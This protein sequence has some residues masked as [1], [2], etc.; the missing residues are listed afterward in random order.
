MAQVIH[1]S[2]ASFL[3][4][5]LFDQ[6]AMESLA[7]VIEEQRIQLEANKKRLIEN[8]VRREKNH[9]EKAGRY[10]NLTSDQAKE[11]DRK[12][13]KEVEDDPAYRDDGCVFTLTLSN[14]H[15]VK[16]S[17]LK[18]AAEDAECQSQYVKKLEVSMSYGGV[19]VNLVIPS[20]EKKNDLQIVTL[21]EGSDQAKEAFVKL[22]IWADNYRP[23]WMRILNGLPPQ[24]IMPIFLIWLLPLAFIVSFANP[25]SRPSHEVEAR[26]LVQKGITP[27]D[28]SKALTILLRRGYEYDNADMRMDKV[29]F[30][31]WG[32]IATLVI[33]T[34]LFTITATTAF[35]IGRGKRSVAWQK[36]YGN[37]LTKGVP[38][39][40]IMGVLAS[41]IGSFIYDKLRG[42]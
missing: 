9:A 1:R 34:I 29:P 21:P 27:D 17:T 37:L 8:T 16:D 33:P 12:I 15:K 35:E 31:F 42:G 4:P 25:R 11:E 14:D 19:K 6:A 13:R 41:T 28:H 10:T 5:W 40:I 23:G 18:G 30:W 22:T 32:A 3:G 2:Q 39:F 36:W 24:L 7:A 20:A 38:G 26:E